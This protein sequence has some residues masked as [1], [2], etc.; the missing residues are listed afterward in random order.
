MRRIVSLVVSGVLSVGVLGSFS[1][2]ADAA[3]I[4]AKQCATCHGKKMEKAYGG[5]GA[6]VVNTLPADQIK[7]EL[8]EYKAGTLNK[9]KQGAVM[10]AQTAKL[11]DEDIA[12]LADYI[13]TLK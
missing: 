12:A 3:G 7:K 13:P 1:F 5:A 4:V 9:L 6:V 10:K 2:A 8:T 11:T